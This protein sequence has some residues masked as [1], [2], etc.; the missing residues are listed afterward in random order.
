MG[1]TQVTQAQWEAVMEG[2]P[3]CFKGANRPV[4]DVGW[5]SVQEFLKK[6]NA[7]LGKADGGTMALPT[8][9]QWEYAA[10]ARQPGVY[11]GGSLDQVAWYDGNSDHETP[12]VGT[13]KANA[14]GLHDMSGN[15][16][17]WCHDWYDET[18]QGGVDPIGPDSGSLRVIRGGG[19]A[20]EAGYCRVASRY[21]DLP[22]G[23][24][25]IYYIGFRVSR[26]PFS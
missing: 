11:A 18:L 21:A 5:S 2:N 20:D 6:L 17:E 23:C 1:K 14:W 15:V 24:S 25:G 7:R 12:P 22:T 4:E 19:W 3:S 8:E 16:W 9:A 26:R 10:R 13:K